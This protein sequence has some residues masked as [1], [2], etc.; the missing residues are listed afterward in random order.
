[1]RAAT[2]EAGDRAPNF[3]HTRKFEKTVRALV[4]KTA[5]TLARRKWKIMRSFFIADTKINTCRAPFFS[6]WRNSFAPFLSKLRKQMRELM[7]K[8]AIDFRV[9]KV[10]KT[11]IERDQFVSEVSATGAAFQACVPFHA[12]VVRDATSAKRAQQ[13]ACFQ[14]KIDIVVAASLCEARRVPQGRGYSCRSSERQ[15]ELLKRQRIRCLS[16]W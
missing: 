7:T 4:K 11:R 12:N 5:R 16:F 3:S 15:L 1:M 2:G 9:A 6:V 14:F 13:L 10:T 8:C